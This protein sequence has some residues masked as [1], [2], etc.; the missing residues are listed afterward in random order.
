MS[1]SPTLGRWLEEDPEGYV[2]G[3]NHY[4]TD[5]SNPV[6]LV[7]PMGLQATQ[8]SLPVFKGFEGD[9]YQ[10]H[11][12]LI[13]EL[14]ADFNAHKDKYCGCTDKQKGGVSNLDPAMVKAWLIQ[15]SGGNT[16]QDKAAWNT[17]PAQVNVPGDWNPYK[18]DIGLKQPKQRNEGDLRTNLMAALKYLCRKGFG[19]SG[20]PARNRPN[21]FFDDWRTALERYNGR[22]QN[23]TNGN[24]YDKN[25]AGRIWDRYQNPGIYYPIELPAPGK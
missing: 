10:Q 22:T 11:D 6:A 8:P 2:N 24:P 23:T 20:Q 16:D 18:G 19:S 1:Y 25:Y 9:R 12:A 15:E 3:A 4:Q 7:D 17:D 14:V 5:L 13:N 21:G